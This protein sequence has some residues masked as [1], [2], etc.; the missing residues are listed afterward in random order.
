MLKEIFRGRGVGCGAVI[1]ELRS[2]AAL[3][4]RATLNEKP[5]RV[6]VFCRDTDDAAALPKGSVL[7][8]VCHPN[9]KGLRDLW[10]LGI[11][12]LITDTSLLPPEK[13]E[14]KNA[15]L[16]AEGGRLT[17]DPDL[18]ALEEFSKQVRRRDDLEAKLAE[19]EELPSVTL[20]G[21]Q[22]ALLSSV[23]PSIDPTHSPSAHSEVASACIFRDG[24]VLLR[25]DTSHIRD[26][27][28]E[29]QISLYESFAPKQ[30]ILMIKVLPPRDYRGAK[31]EQSR[32]LRAI[33]RAAA[34]RPIAILMGEIH[35]PEEARR[36]QAFLIETKNRLRYDC[37]PFGKPLAWGILLHTPKAVI[38]SDLLAAETDFFIFDTELLCPDTNAPWD[39]AREGTDG[40]TLRL[41]EL[42]VKGYT[43]GKA[44]RKKSAPFE[45]GRSRQPSQLSVGICGALAGDRDFLSRAA[46]LS[47]DLVAL[48]SSFI[49][50][51]KMIIRELE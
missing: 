30:G 27:G 4:S 2:A 39:A 33:L 49:P 37:V 1:G 9:T 13:L 28:E 51:A 23:K 22:I 40:A 16:D 48:P 6:I 38:L 8:A 44:L 35:C 5:D 50:S 17:T 21:R 47:V 29:E 24:G 18:D 43:A 31:E 45:A 26:L 34:H 20:S 3:I 36:R 15:I 25:A 46:A 19:L 7:G 10:E 14:G 41:L 42:A 12:M 11:P 32:Q